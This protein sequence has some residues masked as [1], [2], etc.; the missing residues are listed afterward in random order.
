MR[1][2][3]IRKERT[4]LIKGNIMRNPNVLNNRVLIMISFMLRVITKK[5]TLD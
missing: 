2:V 5:D 1:G 3:T 4:R